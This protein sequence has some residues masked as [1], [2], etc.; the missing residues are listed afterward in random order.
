MCV[1]VCVCVLFVAELGSLTEAAPALVREGPSQCSEGERSSKAGYEELA[2]LRNGEPVVLIQMIHVG[3]LCPVC[4]RHD[5]VH[6]EEPPLKLSAIQ[7]AQM[8]HMSL[9]LQMKLDHSLCVL[10]C[11]CA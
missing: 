1:C 6:S 7:R 9:G 2:V 3:P 10:F 5:K 11:V 8:I 4:R